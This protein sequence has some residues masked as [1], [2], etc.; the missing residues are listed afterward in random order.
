MKYKDIEGAMPITSIQ[1]ELDKR[2]QQFVQDLTGPVIGKYFAREE[3]GHKIR[4]YGK[5]LSTK[6]YLNI[7]SKY[8]PFSVE[9]TYK[10]LNGK[11]K[12][13]SVRM[14][15]FPAELHFFDTEDEMNLF[16]EVQ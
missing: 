16:K 1:S 9:I 13:V 5:I 14:Y 8:C 2:H 6:F 4:R 11:I 12:T 15:E 7:S 10:N 3:W